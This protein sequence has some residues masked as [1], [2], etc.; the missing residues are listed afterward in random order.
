V[1][2]F[3]TIYFISYYIVPLMIVLIQSRYMYDIHA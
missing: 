2:Y 3:V 1:V